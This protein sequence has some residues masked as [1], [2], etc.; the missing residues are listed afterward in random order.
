[1]YPEEKPK[2]T[3]QPHW[4]DNTATSRQQKRRTALNELAQQHG[5]KSWSE[6]ET[7][8]LSGKAQIVVTEKGSEE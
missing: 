5:F 3:H 4:Q 2:R 6:L 1:M 8:A 7:A